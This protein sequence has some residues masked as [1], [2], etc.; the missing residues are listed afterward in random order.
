[1]YKKNVYEIYMLITVRMPD[2][3]FDFVYVV[4]IR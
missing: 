1:M 3:V 4:G 2:A